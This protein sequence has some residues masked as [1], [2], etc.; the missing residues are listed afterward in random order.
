MKY[1]S[2]ILII[3]STVNEDKNILLGKL[4]TNTINNSFK[5][6]LYDIGLKYEL[7]TNLIRFIT[8]V[9]DSEHLNSSEFTSLYLMMF[10]TYNLLN[11]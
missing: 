5:P 10:A 7:P 1:F 9:D 11:G 3:Y 2:N 6:I 4:Q 8:S